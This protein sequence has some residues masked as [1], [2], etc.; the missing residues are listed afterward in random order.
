MNEERSRRRQRAPRSRDIQ[1][2]LAALGPVENPYPP[3]DV[4]SPEGLS[5][6]V[7]AAFLHRARDGVVELVLVEWKYTESY[8]VRA[9]D[10]AKDSVRFGRYGDEHLR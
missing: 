5:R 3:I 2:Q 8:R 7:D 6:I 4:L 9:A 1:S 10:P